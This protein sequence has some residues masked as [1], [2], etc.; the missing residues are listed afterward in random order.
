MALAIDTWTDV[1]QQQP[2]FSR[3]ENLINLFYCTYTD[4]TNPFSLAHYLFP[5]SILP[6]SLINLNWGNFYMEETSFKNY[7]A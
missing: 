1:I 2:G 3:H 4:L 5:A 6:W 7:G